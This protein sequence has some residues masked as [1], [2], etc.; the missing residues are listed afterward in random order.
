MW[1]KSGTRDTQPLQL[2]GTAIHLPIANEN[3]KDNHCQTTEKER[4]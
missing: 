1:K 4:S 3:A 2:Q